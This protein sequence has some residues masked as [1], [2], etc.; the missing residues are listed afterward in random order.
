MS[1]SNANS[2]LPRAKGIDMATFYGPKECVKKAKRIVLPSQNRR[3][4]EEFIAILGMKEKFEAYEVPIPN[5]IVMCG[6][7]GTGKTLTSF[8]LAARLQLPLIVVRLDASQSK[9][10]IEDGPL[11]VRHVEEAYEEY[12]PRLAPI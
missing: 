8:Y 11:G 4:V 7:P 12:A 6:P 5:K 2:R 1:K 3:I 9:A 10:I